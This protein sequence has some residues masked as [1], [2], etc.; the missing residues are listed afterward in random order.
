[1]GCQR[2]ESTKQKL[3]DDMPS[4]LIARRR[5]EESVA[6]RRTRTFDLLPDRVL[7]GSI[8]HTGAAANPQCLSCRIRRVFETCDAEL[9]SVASNGTINPL[10][11]CI[12]AAGV[13][14]NKDFGKWRMPDLK[15]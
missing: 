14:A 13:S 10:L 1:M 4:G 12:V 11:G 8:R 9:E 2:M 3:T 5:R 6:L 15:A 7:S